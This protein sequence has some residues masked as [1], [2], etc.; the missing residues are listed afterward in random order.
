M[1]EEL[2]R[3]QKENKA[4]IERVKVLE[5]A[6]VKAEAD[7][8]DLKTRNDYLTKKVFG[9]STEKYDPDQAELALGLAPAEVTEKPKVILFPVTTYRKV[10]KRRKPRIP[11]NIPTKDIIIEPEEVKQSPQDYR[12]IGE[13]ITKELEVIP[14]VYH[15]LRYIRRKYTS[16]KNRDMAPIIAELPARLIEGGYAGPGLLTDIILKKY[17]DHLPLYRQ[18]QILLSRYGIYLPRKTMCDWVWK[19][20]DWLKPIYRHIRDE[21]IGGKYLQIDETPVR[22]C[23]AEGGGSA[24]GYFWVYHRPGS[25]VL[26][27]WRT[28]RSADC[29]KPMLDGFTGT[30]QSDAYGAYG[31]YANARNQRALDA[32]LQI[33]ITLAACWAHV[34]RKIF[35]ALQESPA[36]AG[37]LLHQ[38]GMM[39]RIEE[40]LRAGKA[41]PNLRQAV[42]SAKSG[43]ILSRIYSVLNKKAT[44]V[45]PRSQMGVAIKYALGIWEE[46]VRFRDDG[47]IEI[48]NNLVEN[49]IRPTAIGKKNWLFIGHPEAGDR[50]AIIYTI[51]EN[52]KKLGINPQEYLYNVLSRLP[53]MTNHQTHELTPANWL[54]AKKDKAA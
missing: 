32:G 9:R 40:E 46:L 30:V 11:D 3:L 23:L 53:S 39:Y 41:G 48:D 15:C 5:A 16:N 6:L 2:E 27:E 51:L 38:I 54:A 34:R 33:A 26:Y 13:E 28:S 19:V 49:A 12:L 17:M 43:M 47:Q 22:Y 1:R 31:S 52:C 8:R 35:D 36:L 25:G 7:N 21:L 14:P 37:W 29:L 44:T 42:R 50:S 24:Q 20:A 4:L 18:E 45:L 10:T